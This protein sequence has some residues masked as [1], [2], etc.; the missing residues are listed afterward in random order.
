LRRAVPLPSSVARR[1][2]A[3]AEECPPI[4]V[5]L[6]WGS[7]TGKPCTVTLYVYTANRE[8]VSR[9]GRPQRARLYPAD[10]HQPPTDERGPDPRAIDRAFGDDQD[11]GLDAD[12]GLETA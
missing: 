5:A 2:I 1:L 4:P 8:P 12:D 10:L 7:S 11:D 6:P 9:P 3:H